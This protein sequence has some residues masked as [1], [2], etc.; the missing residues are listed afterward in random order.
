MMHIT[1]LPE[2]AKDY[3][4]LSANAYKRARRMRDNG[5]EAWI[6]AS[7]QDD[8]AG[9]A[10]QAR[11]YLYGSFTKDHPSDLLSLSDI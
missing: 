3:Q 10:W 6:I 4:D 5:A 9:L 8:A 1:N 2:R 11:L 7:A